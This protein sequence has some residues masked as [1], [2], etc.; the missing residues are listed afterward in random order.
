MMIL[1]ILLDICFCFF[2]DAINQLKKWL[3]NPIGNKQQRNSRGIS[4]SGRRIK[5]VSQLKKDGMKK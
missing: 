1:F 5:F 2:Y 3:I 4:A